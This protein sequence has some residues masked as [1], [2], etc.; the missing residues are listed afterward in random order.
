MGLRAQPGQCQRAAGS[1]DGVAASLP[2][3]V[4][5]FSCDPAVPEAAVL[6]VQLFVSQLGQGKARGWLQNMGQEGNRHC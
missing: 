3:S 2:W 6:G 5:H 4:V 1:A